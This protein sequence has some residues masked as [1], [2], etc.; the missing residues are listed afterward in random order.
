MFA[1]MK[2]VYTHSDV[3]RFAVDSCI[4]SQFWPVV[5]RVPFFRS[6]KRRAGFTSPNGPPT[7]GA[8]SAF[9]LGAV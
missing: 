4:A 2:E 7:T 6:L 9:Y 8:N 3:A 5:F 1:S